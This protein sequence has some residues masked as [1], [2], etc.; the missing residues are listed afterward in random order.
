MPGS[1]FGRNA[2]TTEAA[3]AQRTRAIAFMF[4]DNDFQKTYKLEMNA[5]RWFSRDM[6]TDSNACIVNETLLKAFGIEDPLG[7]NILMVNGEKSYLRLNII[8]VT[9]DFNNESLHQNIGPLI[10]LHQLN[11]GFISIRLQKGNPTVSISKIKKIWDKFLPDQPFIY[12]FLGDD[13][14]TLYKNDQR[15]RDIFGIFSLLSIFIAALGLMGIAAFHAERR[16]KEIGIRKVMGAS[17]PSILGLMTR[18]VFIFTGIATILAW[19]PSYFLMQKWLNNFAYKIE[20]TP[21]IFIV[22]SILAL[23]IALITVIYQSFAAA[24][25]N[26]AIAIR[27]E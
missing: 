22:A 21:I 7:K 26:P 24:K 23:I 6:P 18:E 27:Y 13:L 4:T 20:M 14:M 1:I 16:T 11:F 3:G 9:K 2:F 19:I 12:S 10:I 5:G 8:G 25:A 17:I 15:S